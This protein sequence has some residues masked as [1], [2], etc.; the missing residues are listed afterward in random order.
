[1]SGVTWDNADKSVFQT[2]T[3]TAT[4]LD[5]DVRKLFVDWDDGKNQT[6]EEGTNQWINLEKP[7]KTATITHTYTQTGTFNPV[8]RTVNGDG[9][10]SKYYG[11]SSTNADLAPYEQVTRIDG[12]N[13]SDGKPLS[14]L[15]IENKEVLSGIDNNIF[16]EGPKDVYIQVPPLTLSGSNIDDRNIKIEVECI[17]AEALSENQFDLGYQVFTKTL[18]N[19]F[20]LSDK[21]GGIGEEDAIL[22]NAEEGDESINQQKILSV[23]KITMKT[24]KLFDASNEPFTNAD[25]N[26]FNKIKIFLT[27]KGDDGYFYP[28]TYISNGDIIKSLGDVQRQTILDFAQSRAKASNVN[29]E[30][31][32]YDSGKV[33]W[34]PEKQWQASSSTA[35]TDATSVTDSLVKEQYT[36]YP[37]PDGL[38]GSF[39]LDSGSGSCALYSGN[40]FTHG[41]GVH[42]QDFI[43]N[44]FLI[45]QFNQFVP[46][47]HLARMSATSFSSSSSSVDIFESTL[48]ICPVND[49]DTDNGWYLNAQSRTEDLTTNAYKNT[50]AYGVSTSSWNNVSYVSSGGANRP[51]SEYF[52]LANTGKTNKVFFNNSSYANEFMT[53]VSGASG[54]MI[55]GVY[56]L[57]L[58][59]EKAGDKFTQKAEWMP[60]E[61]EDTTKISIKYTDNDDETEVSKE[62]SFAKSGYLSFDMPDDWSKTSIQ[63]LTGGFFSMSGQAVEETRAL[64]DYTISCSAL[65]LGPTTDQTPFDYI[66]LTGSSIGTQLAGYT[67]K[68]IGNFKYI[69]Q[70]N[71]PSGTLY[72]GK[73]F[74]VA[75]SSIGSNKLYLASGSDMEAGCLPQTPAG[76]TNFGGLIRRINIY[77]VFDGASKTSDTG[78]PP[79]YVAL[80]NSSPSTGAYRYEFPFGSG[81][82]STISAPTLSG[83]FQNV[84]PLKITIGGNFSK[85]GAGG[86]NGPNQEIWNILPAVSSSTQMI[87]QK[88]SSAYDISSLAITSDVSIARAGTFYQAITKQGKVYIVRTGT[89]IQSIT[90]T[91]IAQGDESTFSFNAPYTTYGTLLKLR[92]AQAESSRV[93]WDEVQK[94]GTYVRYFGVITSVNETHSAKGRRA[95]RAFTATMVIQEIA[96]ISSGAEMSVGGEIYTDITPLGG[97]ADAR[98]FL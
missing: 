76:V 80:P 37:R 34:E 95:N 44:Q 35:Y 55:T 22:L 64:N 69:F 97:I 53:N 41:T 61:F 52:V 28:I 18:S 60:V 5:N 3:G 83:S 90:F 65:T 26:L 58:S 32:H 88:D 16:G 12:I 67:D 23:L 77:D 50:N 78:S 45:N 98:S 39:T 94:D 62:G 68:Q 43:R 4:F 82:D 17:V 1:M 21:E 96:L 93:M 89:P 42:S 87:V 48:R 40:T 8:L 25:A 27:A 19:T 20:K 11:S 15:K 74:W 6:I 2:V 14:Q 13:I 36:Y 56:Y 66:E 79:N 84:Y 63:D 86:S 46:Q 72:T 47:Y 24:V 33:F 57:K 49:P 70:F 81:S 51:A 29:I 7:S 54:A 38:R 31:Y 85:F 71:E 92:D 59:N 75:S 10:V 9:F 73:V 30:K 91:S